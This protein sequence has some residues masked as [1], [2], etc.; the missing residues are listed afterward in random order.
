MPNVSANEVV[1]YQKQWSMTE[2]AIIEISVTEFENG[3]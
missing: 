1:F 3:V 2:A